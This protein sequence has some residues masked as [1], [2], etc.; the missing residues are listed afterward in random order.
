MQHLM[1]EKST[2]N[3]NIV[4]SESDFNVHNPLPAKRSTGSGGQY[5]RYSI[6]AQTSS[7][8]IADVI[9]FMPFFWERSASVTLAETGVEQFL[10]KIQSFALLQENWDGHG[11]FPPSQRAI[12]DAATLLKTLTEISIP[13]RVGVSGDGEISLIW[14]E[15]G[16]FADFGD[17]TFSFFAN[18]KGKDFFGDD[19]SLSGDFRESVLSVFQK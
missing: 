11:G 3:S 15:S 16:F 10:E 14:N 2:G 7:S 9:P 6:N 1:E 17:G 8:E 13:L 19:I 5:V 4:L 18:R 12:A